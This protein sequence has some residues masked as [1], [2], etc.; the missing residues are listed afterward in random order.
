MRPSGKK[1]TGV[2][3]RVVGLV[4]VPVNS[5][6]ERICRGKEHFRKKQHASHPPLDIQSKTVNVILFHKMIK[7][8][9]FFLNVVLAG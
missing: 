9:G 2:M 1:N 5:L 4:S 7:T 6:S 3:D 8:V